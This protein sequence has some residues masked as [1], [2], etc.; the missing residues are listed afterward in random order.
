MKTDLH[1]IK[2]KALELFR[3]KE[4]NEAFDYLFEN[5]DENNAWRNQ[6]YVLSARRNSLERD[7]ISEIITKEA[8]IISKNRIYRNFSEIVNLLEETFEEEETDYNE[9]YYISSNYSSTY[10]PNESLLIAI[11][12]LLVLLVIGVIFIIIKLN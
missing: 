5:L 2:T 10:T 9:P 11:I 12:V 7:R 8:Y 1:E 4:I 3:N 6:L